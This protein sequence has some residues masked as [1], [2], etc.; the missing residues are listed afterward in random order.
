MSTSKSSKPKNTFG[1]RLK[2][3]RKVLGLTQAKFAEPIGITH[4]YV[5]DLEKGKVQK[6]SEPVIQAIT[7]SYRLNRN[8]LLY[9]E[10]EMFLEHRDEGV[11]RELLPTSPIVAVDVDLLA[12]VV[13]GVESELEKRQMT[14]AHD[15]KAKIIALLYDYFS[16][17]KQM[18]DMKKIKDYL[19]LLS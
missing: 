16:K 17:A 10:G 7:N 12:G 4:G 2:Q 11:E 15:K 6:P 3:A 5:S 18:V 9:G 14:L 13:E 19:S 8:M 1:A